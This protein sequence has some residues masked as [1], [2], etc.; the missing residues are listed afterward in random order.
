MSWK[1]IITFLSCL[2]Y[3]ASCNSKKTDEKNKSISWSIEKLKDNSYDKRE[4]LFHNR[5]K[6]QEIYFKQNKI[7]LVRLHDTLLNENLEDNFSKK[8][9]D[10]SITYFF[11]DWGDQDTLKVRFW[12]PVKRNKRYWYILKRDN[13]IVLNIEITD[14]PVFGFTEKILPGSHKYTGVIK[15]LESEYEELVIEEKEGVMIY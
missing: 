12:K 8:T 9:F 5:Q 15:T 6:I 10:E 13:K 1:I 14:N 7:S 11:P 3:F 4:T 2:F